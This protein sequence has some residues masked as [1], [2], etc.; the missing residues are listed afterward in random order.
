M[1]D[2]VSF[3]INL[4]TSGFR[5]TAFGYDKCVCS[6]PS[7]VRYFEKIA[8]LDPK[9]NENDPKSR[10]G[11]KMPKMAHH[12]QGGELAQTRGQRVPRTSFQAASS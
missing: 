1:S 12:G 11:P 9:T 6:I 5:T 8:F 3:R 10:K 7:I 2:H 4:A